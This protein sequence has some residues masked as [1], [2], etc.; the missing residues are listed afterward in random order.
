MFKKL[1]Q[2]F[3]SKNNSPDEKEYKR[4]PLFDL[5]LGKL[6]HFDKSDIEFNQQL[7][8]S[9]VKELPEH[10]VIEAVSH[11]ELGMGSCIKRFY[12]DDDVYFQVN[13]TGSQ[14][15]SNVDDVLFFSYRTDK[16]LVLSSQKD[17]D[18]WAM[19]M[20]MATFVFDD[21][22][23]ERV[24]DSGEEFGTLAEAEE[25]VTN[26]EGSRYKLTNTFM[27]FRRDI[28]GGSE[29]LLLVCLE[30]EGDDSVSVSFAV[31]CSINGTSIDVSM[32]S[33]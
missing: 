19:K 14:E 27:L 31:G 21:V 2:L 22:T 33:I 18:N 7:G 17:V 1:G 3:A 5:G 8:L 6:V 24:F 16:T 20:K 13:Y 30:D 12:G 15:E 23:F 32:A 25:S 10:V 4:E 29:E 28:E 9:L 26:R 11:I